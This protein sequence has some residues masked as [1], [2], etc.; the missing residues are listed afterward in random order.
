MKPLTPNSTFS[1]LSPGDRNG[2]SG[3]AQ[4]M[5]FQAGRLFYRFGDH[6]GLRPWW[7][8][9]S[10]LNDTLIAAKNSG[11][12]L[13]QY[14]RETS[15]IA[16]VWGGGLTY[17][18]VIRLTQEMYAFVGTIAPQN[19]AA[20]IG[21][22]RQLPSGQRANQDRQYPPKYYT[23]SVHYK[24]GGSQVYMPGL[25]FQNCQ[26]VIPEK[27]VLIHDDINDILDFLKTYHIL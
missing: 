25:T 24:G 4:L 2:F 7:V 22:D 13:Y 15:A 3:S 11:K 12:T 9:A 8:E 27:T 14:I 26:S 23:K 16:R 21:A 5:P 17:L 10:R 20:L 6:D 18:V 19:D 1:E